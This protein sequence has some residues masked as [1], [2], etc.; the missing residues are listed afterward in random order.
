MS[1]SRSTSWSNSTLGYR[2]RACRSGVCA[3]CWQT[4]ETIRRNTPVRETADFWQE[5]Q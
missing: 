2:N 4:D 3:F 1:L 5:E